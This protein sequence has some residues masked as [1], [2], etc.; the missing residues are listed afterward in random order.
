LVYDLFKGNFLYKSGI[1]G[2]GMDVL[3]IDDCGKII[4][5]FREIRK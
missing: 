5:K 4:C 2:G 3:L 1:I